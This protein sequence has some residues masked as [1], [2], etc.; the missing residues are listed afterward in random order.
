MLE[1]QQPVKYTKPELEEK[2]MLL[3]KLGVCLNDKHIMSQV[4]ENPKQE[5]LE[6]LELRSKKDFL[7]LIKQLML[8]DLITS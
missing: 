2:Y 5:F 8:C 6:I 4:L 7:N 3:V 1:N